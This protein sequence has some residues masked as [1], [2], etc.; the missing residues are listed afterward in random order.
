MKLKLHVSFI[1]AL[2]ACFQLNAQAEKCATMRV[3]E[4]R[5]MQD[6]GTLIRK[7][8]LENTIQNMISAEGS[9]KKTRNVITIPVVVH[10]VYNNN[11]ENVSTAQINSQIASLNEDFRLLNSDSLMDDHI[12]WPVTADAQIEF[13]LAS[14][15]PDGNATTGITRTFTSMTSFDGNGEEKFTTMGGHDGWDP[16]RY[17]NMWVCDL[18]AAGLLGYA[19]FPSDLNDWP[20]YDGVVINY[21]AFGTMGSAVSPN[22]LGRTATHEVGHWLNLYHIWG[23]ADCGNDLVNDTEVAF[24]ANYGC[25]NFPF[26]ENSS[27]GSGPAGEMYMNYMDY[28]D[29]GCMMMFTLGQTQRMRAALNAARSGLLTSTACESASLDELFAGSFE[30]YPNP[31]SDV[32]QIDSPLENNVQVML[33]NILGEEI[34]SSREIQHFPFELDVRNLPVGSYLLTFTNGMNSVTR[35]VFVTR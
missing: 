16:I 3:Y 24:E 6:P 5:V 10:V 34:M 1:L 21:S 20:E 19:T 31:A 28:V 35:K 25:P 18:D 17:L 15:D 8:L 7:Q 29:D 4:E 12:F 33:S 32:I 2:T 26:N 13:C 9:E 22:N 11:T 23:D 30:I 27:C 14:T